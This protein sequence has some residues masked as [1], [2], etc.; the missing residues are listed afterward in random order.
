VETVQIRNLVLTVV[1]DV[2]QVTEGSF[3]P[4]SKPKR[5]AEPRRN[6]S[7]SKLIFAIA[8][9]Y[10][11]KNVR[12]IG[13]G[14]LIDQTIESNGWLVMPMDKYKC[15]IPPEVM[16][17]AETLT[18]G[19]PI[20]GFLVAEDRRRLEQQSQ[21][22]VLTA[23]EPSPDWGKIAGITGKVAATIA[24]VGLTISFLP[25]V[26]GVAAIGAALSYDPLLIAVTA[27]DEWIVVGEWWD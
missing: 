26:L 13:Y 25:L 4:A 19:I 16:Q 3:F 14:S 1:P 17:Q 23:A 24:V 9:K 20:K 27:E 18:K 12:L 22:K 5:K 11:F 21:K 15:I 6:V 8:K 7:Q 2:A 10:G